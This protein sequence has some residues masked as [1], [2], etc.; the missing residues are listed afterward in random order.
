[1]I[2][3]PPSTLVGKNVPKTAFYKHLEVNAKLK[4]SFVACIDRLEWWAKLAPSTLNVEDG[5]AVHEITVFWVTLKSDDVPLDVF[6]TIDRQMPRHVVFV[7]QWGERF[8]LLLNYKEWIDPEKGTFRVIRSFRTPW[9]DGDSL[10]LT[11]DGSTMDKVYESFA[12]QISG[13]DTSCAVDMKHLIDLRQQV[14]VMKRQIVA[15]QKRIKTERQFNRQIELNQEAR[16][17]K[18]S[19]R[20]L[21][22][23]L[24]Q[25]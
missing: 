23:Q 6:T 9:T 21:Q 16:T 4:A 8:C 18:A 14:E 25:L 24:P 3:F 10:R 11:I 12:G 15:L 1:M 20:E 5:K 7:L 17:L 13:F 22:K 2:R 19:L